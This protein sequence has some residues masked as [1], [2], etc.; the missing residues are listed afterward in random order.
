[1]SKGLKRLAGVVLLTVLAGAAAWA[2]QAPQ[3][4]AQSPPSADVGAAGAPNATFK[5]EVEYVEVDV[6]VTDDKGKPVRGLTRDDFE[7]FEDGK[8]QTIANFTVVNIPTEPLDPSLLQPEAIEPDAVGNER[9]FSGRLYVIVLDDI[10]IAFLR[11]Q[12]VKNAARQFI[13]RNLGANDLMAIVHTGGLS[14]WSQEFTNNKRLLL[15]AVD[16]FMGQK[17]P[18]SVLTRNAEY[19]RQKDNA[20]A[21]RGTL[22]LDSS[23]GRDPLSQERLV[24]ASSALNTIRSVA[25]WYGG[26][27]GRRKTML[28]FSEGIELGNDLTDLMSQ[29]G[30]GSFGASAILADAQGAIAAAT[31]ANVSIYSIDPRGLTAMGDDDITVSRWANEPGLSQAGLN[32]ERLR[33]HMS[34]RIVSE[35]T[36]GFTVVNTNQFAEAFDRIVDENSAYYVLAYYPPSNKRDG[37]FHTIKVKTTRPGLDVRSRKGYQAPRGKVPTSKPTAAGRP[38]PELQEALDSP[39]PVSGLPMRAFAAPFKSTAPNASVLVGVELAGRNL[40][41]EQNGR[42]ELSYAAVDAQ[43]KIRAASTDNFTI[44]LKPETRARAQ[45]SGFR[46]LNR[47]A[48]PPGRYAIRLAARDAAAGATGSVT[49]DLEVPDF[50]KPALSLS[51]VLL[52]SMSGSAMVIAKA[53]DQTTQVLPASPIA[54][55]TFPQNDEIALFAEI[56]DNQTGPA[57]RVD[58]STTIQADDGRVLFRV[59]DARNSSDLQRDKGGHGYAL[60][61]PLS[62]IAPGA[63]V[64]HVQARSRLGDQASVGR[65]IRIVVTPSAGASPLSFAASSAGDVTSTATLDADYARLS[66]TYRSGDIVSAVGEIVRWPEERIKAARGGAKASPEGMARTVSML[67]IEAAFALLPDRRADSHFSAAE[68]FVEALPKQDADGFAARWR[69]FAATYDV[70]RGRMTDAQVRVR[71]ARGKGVH[72]RHAELMLVALQEFDVRRRINGRVRDIESAFEMGT[73]L[74]PAYGRVAEEYPDFLAARLRWGWAL[75]INRSPNARAL[76]ETVATRATRPDLRYLAHLFLGAVA[77]REN[78]LDDA[79]RAYDAAVA[80]IPQQSALIGLIAVAGALGDDERMLRATRT[81][82]GLSPVNGDD[83]WTQYNNG[84]TGDEL[85]AELRAAARQ[86]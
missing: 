28:L 18:S 32:N 67:H 7:L 68:A 57:H 24:K 71:L 8:R 2:G 10:N 5:A 44:N 75:Y 36:G 3:G 59:E 50:R 74:A 33:E 39:I 54:A 43:G 17:L 31:R 49:Y 81:L 40:A 20:E 62:E 56:Y 4:Q 72:S 41:L 63:Y 16:R 34:L 21:S 23:A 48:L 61:I 65:Q 30:L 22:T 69:V 26:I 35:Q 1:M 45:Q 84:F 60:R 83:P 66:A 27:R 76:L 11:S 73:S 19:I 82:Q 58:I 25:D 64:L 9:P 15:N 42:I 70:M 46:V 77:E 6:V 80:A 12:Q 29:D 78:R 38:S 79:V 47:I 37:K 14:G 86:P 13:E 55:R 52:T 85:L 53:D 51:G